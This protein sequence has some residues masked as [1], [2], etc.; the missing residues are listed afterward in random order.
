MFAIT[1]V[2]LCLRVYI[3]LRLLLLLQTGC[4]KANKT[5]PLEPVYPTSTTGEVFP[6]AQYQLPRSVRPVGYDLTLNPDLDRMVFTGTTVITLL[7]CHSTN[8]IVLHSAN[9][10]I[11][12]ATFKV[13]LR[14][15]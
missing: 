13:G 9:L 4:R 1:A 6:W 10:N 5:A 3:R 15:C 8:R 2:P 12:K 14:C 7:V 11:T